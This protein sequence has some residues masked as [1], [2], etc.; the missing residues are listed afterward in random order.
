[1][2]QLLLQP[3]LEKRSEQILFAAEVPVKPA[4]RKAKVAH[5]SSDARPS[6]PSAFG[7]AVMRSVLGTIRCRVL[8]LGCGAYIA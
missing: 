3:L 6:R 1:V 8:L 5:K 7:I 2:C 4:V